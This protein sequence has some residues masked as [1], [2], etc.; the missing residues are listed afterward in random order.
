LRLRELGVDDAMCIGSP[1][2]FHPDVQVKVSRD[3]S[4]ADYPRLVKE[5]R[6]P[7]GALRM[8]IKK[9]PDYLHDDP[10]IFSDYNWSRADELLVKGPDDLEKLRY[11]LCDPAKCDLSAFR[12]NAKKVME[13]ASEEQLLTTCSLISPMTFA[14]AIVGG[15][16]MIYESADHPAFVEELLDIITEWDKQVMAVCLDMGVDV[17]RFQGPYDGTAFWTPNQFKTVSAPRLKEFSALVHQGGAKIVYW[18]DGYIMKLL[19]TFRDCGLDAVAPLNPPPLADANLPEIKRRIG[20]KVCLWGGI[21]APVT[22][23]QRSKE[24]VRQAVIDAIRAAGPGG[25]FI[26]APADAIMVE[27]AYENLMTMIQTCHEFGK[28][29]LAR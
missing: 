1:H 28:Y 6:T 20:D 29:P 11:V 15:Q 25:G 27:S 16:K 14:M 22:I 9:T 17:V 23:E 2:L 13:F 5:I 24:E 21:S 19:E 10:P 18:A 8:I 7:R 3:D 26:L 4:H 12:E